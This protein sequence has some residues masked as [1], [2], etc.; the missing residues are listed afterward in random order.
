MSFIEVAKISEIPP[1]TMKHIETGGKEI[2]IVNISGRFYAIG[3]RC[4]H[5]NARL[6]TGTLQGTV[7]TCPMHFSRFDVTTGKLLSGPQL[8]TG[9]AAKMFGRCPEDVQKAMGQMF[10][11]LRR[12]RV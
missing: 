3:D 9:D 11:L 1:G 8:E 2:C 4:G 10:S 5:E 7:V 12:I 6:S